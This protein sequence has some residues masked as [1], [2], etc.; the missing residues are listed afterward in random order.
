[1]VKKAD[2]FSGILSGLLAEQ[3]KVSASDNAETHSRPKRTPYIPHERVARLAASKSKRQPHVD[4]EAETE[5]PCDEDNSPYVEKLE[6]EILRLTEYAAKAEETK[7]SLRR[8]E[9]LRKHLAYIIFVII[10]IWLVCVFGLV[11]LGSLDVYYF[12]GNCDLS[13]RNLF[14]RATQIM[15]ATCEFIG[16]G[17]VLNLSEKIVIALITT[18]TINILGLAYIVARWLYPDPNGKKKNKTKKVDTSVADPVEN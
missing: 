4:K 17:S 2:R 1:M 18:T 12:K 10:A 3:D 14:F 7:E 16:K 8:L 11:F 13:E 15:P 6:A 9:N 5:Q